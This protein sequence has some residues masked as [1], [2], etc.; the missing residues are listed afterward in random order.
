MFCKIC[1]T[2]TNENIGI[3]SKGMAEAL[4]LIIQLISN[5]SFLCNF[6]DILHPIV[7][8]IPISML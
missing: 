5:H 7:Q 3:S 8:F 2:K 1:K 6:G 4:K